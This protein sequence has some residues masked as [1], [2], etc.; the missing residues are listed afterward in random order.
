MTYDVYEQDLTHF[1]LFSPMR[2]I[3]KTG[4]EEWD[5]AGSTR[6]SEH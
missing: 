2:A 3:S 6:E 1:F 5:Q 4:L